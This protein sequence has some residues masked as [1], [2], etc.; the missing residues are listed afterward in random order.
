M[1]ANGTSRSSSVTTPSIT[2]TTYGALK[3]SRRMVNGHIRPTS[4]G[5]GNPTRAPSARQTIGRRIVTGVGCGARRMVGRGL[6]P[7]RG[8]GR[9]ITT[10]AGCCA[11]T[12]GLGCRAVNTTAGEVGGGRRWL[13]LCRWIF[14]LVMTFVGIRFL[15]TN[16]IRI[17]GVIAILI[18]RIIRDAGIMVAIVRRL[19][20]ALTVVIDRRAQGLP[21]VR[22]VGGVLLVGAGPRGGCE[23]LITR[24]GV[25][26][27][28]CGAEILVMGISQGDLPMNARRVV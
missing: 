25:E 5:S 16:T 26:S 13:C 22:V 18:E 28:V 7:S 14:L 6:V 8:V 2:T 9:R 11:I 3:N 20:V 24:I 1:I 15:T 23:I 4:V 19:V 27:R 10:V 21:G 17:R 12:S